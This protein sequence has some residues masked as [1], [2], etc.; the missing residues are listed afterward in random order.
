MKKENLPF[1]ICITCKKPFAWR[2]KW[3]LNWERVKYCSK[4]CSAVKI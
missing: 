2:K 1:K 3:K 4:K